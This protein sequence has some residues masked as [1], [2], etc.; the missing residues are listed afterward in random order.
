MSTYIGRNSMA[1][2]VQ[3]C[4]PNE[5]LDDFDI[6]AIVDDLV[7]A[8]PD[9]IGWDYDRPYETEEPQ[10]IDPLVAYLDHWIPAVIGEQRFWDI[11]ARHDISEVRN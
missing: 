11:V 10:A 1:R 9:L 4:L 8:D 7:T 5:N 3:G 2:Y 6:E